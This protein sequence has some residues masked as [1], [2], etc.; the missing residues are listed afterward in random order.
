MELKRVFYLN[1]EQPDL[2]IIDMA[3]S[4]LNNQKIIVYP[5]DTTYAIAVSAIDPIAIQK[6]FDLKARAMDKP[7]HVVVDSLETASQFVVLNR[8]AEI[9]AE[10]FLP[11]PLTLVLP[12]KDTVPDI[13]VAGRKTLGIRIPDNKICQMLAQRLGIPFTTTSANIS[14]G[15]N[16]YTVR[17]VIQQFTDQMEQIDLFLDQGALPKTFPSTLVDLTISPPNILRE[18]PISKSELY[19]ALGAIS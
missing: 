13:L 12:K 10:K 2:S 15:E 6:L 16:P 11:G 17:Q 18:G 14:G 5:T 8:D 4:A 3:V 1:P 19:L 7:L 9:L